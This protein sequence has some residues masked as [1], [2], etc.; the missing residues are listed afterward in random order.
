MDQKRGD[1]FQVIFKQSDKKGHVSRSILDLSIQ[2]MVDHT[3]KH[4]ATARIVVA[5]N[6]RE[7]QVRLRAIFVHAQISLSNHSV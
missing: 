6:N 5:M 2:Q 4:Q 1:S 3:T 7:E